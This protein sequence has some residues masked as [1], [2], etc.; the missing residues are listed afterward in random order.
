MCYAN[1]ECS[2]LIGKESKPG[3]MQIKDNWLGGIL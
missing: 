2:K 1:Y 3:F